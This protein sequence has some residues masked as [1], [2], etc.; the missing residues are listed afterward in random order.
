MIKKKIN[1]SIIIAGILA[2]TLIEITA[3]T[4][5]IDGV[6]LSTIIGIIALAMGILIPSP[7]QIK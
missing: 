1:S 3:L 4:K 5:G 7:I 2:L 6:L